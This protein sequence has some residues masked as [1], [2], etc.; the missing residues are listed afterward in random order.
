[1]QLQSLKETFEYMK[2]SKEK[3]VAGILRI[4]GRKSSGKKRSV[5]LIT[6]LT[7]GCE[8]NGLA[9]FMHIINHRHEIEEKLS[10]ELLLIVNNIRAAEHQFAGTPRVHDGTWYWC[11][12]NMNRLPKDML[13]LQSTDYEIRRA[14]ELYPW[15]AQATCAMDLHA[16]PKRGAAMVIDVK[17]RKPALD[18]V[19]SSIP[20]PIRIQ[21]VTRVQHGVPL[22]YFYGGIGKN[23]PVI[24]V[25]CGENFT[26][27]GQK[28]AIRAAMNFLSPAKHRTQAIYTA[29]WAFRFLDLSYRMVKVLRNFEYV[30]KGQL[31]AT[32]S[33]GDVRAPC[34]GYA[35]FTRIKKQY[36]NPNDIKT[37]V[38]FLA[39][40]TR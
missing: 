30:K 38:M 34:E 18:V 11:D 8:I 37:E 13:S 39:S 21:G 7:H 22:G 1:M 2:S 5:K 4:S 28:I 31:L 3:G 26:R 27:A 20:V 32:S 10:G 15:Y 29:R 9:A 12:A 40:K 14:Q 33:R 16:L 35:L 6:A 17:G 25:E 24:E 23:V 19:A 36:F